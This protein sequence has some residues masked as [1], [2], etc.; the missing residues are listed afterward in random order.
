MR[1]ALGI[2]RVRA[3]PFVVL[4]RLRFKL[5]MRSTLTRYSRSARLAAPVRFVF[6]ALIALWILAALVLPAGYLLTS[7]LH[8]RQGRAA[9]ISWLGTA[10]SGVTFLMFFYGVLTLVGTFT[11]RSDLKLLLM[12]PVS[13]RLILATKI[14]GVSFGFSVLLII[15]LPGLLVVDQQL[16]LTALFLPASVVAI[17][18]APVLPVSLA[19]LMVLAIL[20]FV[21]PA[22]ARAVTTI[23]GTLMGAFLFIGQQAIIAK[24]RS[25][26][27]ASAPPGL[28]DAL[29]STWAGHA[30]AAIGLGHAGDAILFGCAAVLL[31]LSVFALAVEMSARLFQTGAASYQ[32]VARR[33][34]DAPRRNLF[35][36]RAPAGVRFRG[37]QTATR[38]VPALKMPASDT[39][40]RAS[41]RARPVWW[42]LFIK[43]WLLLRRDSQRL[44]ALAYPLL[45][46]GFYFWQLFSFRSESGM[47]TRGVF[48]GSLYG[49]L[50]IASILLLNSTAPSIVNRE[51]RSLYL[52]GL[53]PLRVEDVLLSKWAIAVMPPLILVEVLLVIGSVALGVDP[54][55]A[56]VIAAVMAGL[57]VALVGVSITINLFWPKLVLSNPRQQSSRIASFVGMIGEF[58]LGGVVFGLLGLAFALWQDHFLGSLVVLV[59]LCA[60]L[61]GI[62]TV[63]AVV[64]S[65][66]LDNLLTGDRRAR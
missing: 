52:L 15:T 9:L 7:T 45:V 12:T 1:P 2:N 6:T 37:Q 28:P 10:T 21:P 3:Y 23:L 8:G 30:L 38:R 35:A 24:Q 59:A 54:G 56:L 20:R 62:T 29:P 44:A 50:T 46:I 66:L 27:V 65:R 57:L 22:R 40:T 53:A 33:R 18:L 16:Q 48:F 4:A 51:G 49:V 39:R 25:Q 64:G 43:E 17:V 61:A 34:R 26:V 63:A 41:L 42:P 11:Y 13:T 32:E 5:L 19:T 14:M 60:L 31:A 47:G 58:V 36:A 55:Q